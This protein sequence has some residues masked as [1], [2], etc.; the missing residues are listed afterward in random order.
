MAGYHQQ[1]TCSRPQ[2][3]GDRLGP[4]C[5]GRARRL[6]GRCSNPFLSNGC[7]A[8]K[9]GRLGCLSVS[10]RLNTSSISAN[11][12]GSSWGL[13][14]RHWT[15][16]RTKSTKG[17]ERWA[18]TPKSRWAAVE[19]Q[20]DFATVREALKQTSRPRL[21]IPSGGRPACPDA[22]HSVT[23]FLTSLSRVAERAGICRRRGSGVS[24]VSPLLSEFVYGKTRDA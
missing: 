9:R 11:R 6:Q 7:L 18:S 5:A 2:G 16:R 21:A 12:E 15:S 3:G 8:R 14:P 17:W 4:P 24:S 23:R 13:L 22:G 19:E 10:P 1:L 20:V